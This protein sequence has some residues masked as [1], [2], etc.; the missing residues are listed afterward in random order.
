MIRTLNGQRVGSPRPCPIPFGAEGGAQRPRDREI[1]RGVAAAA[2][3]RRFAAGYSGDCAYRM[4]IAGVVRHGLTETEEITGGVVSSTV[5]TE[6]QL[7]ALP[8]E[9][10]TLQEK[11]SAPSGKVDPDGGT[12]TGAPTPGQLSKTV[13]FRVAAFAQP[14]W[15]R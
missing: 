10:V 8:E 15:D 11:G 4:K 13:G 1:W 9:S 2:S 12:Q 14:A 6:R 3:V 7:L 5:T